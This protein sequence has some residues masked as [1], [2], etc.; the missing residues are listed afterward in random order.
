MTSFMTRS[1][2]ITSS[3]NVGG[4]K[5][6]VQLFPAFQ[7]GCNWVALKFIFLGEVGQSGVART[8]VICRLVDPS[9]NIEPSSGEK[10]EIK[11]FYR[12]GSSIYIWLIKSRDVPASEYLIDDSLTV[13]CAI[14]VLKDLKHITIPSQEEE[15]LPMPPSDMHK[16]FGDLLQ[17]QTGADVTFTVS[18]ESFAAHKL[19]LAARSPVFMA[20]FFGNMEEMSSKCVQIEDMEAAVF[21]AMLHFIYTDTAPE[22]DEDPEAAATL[23]QHL[24]AAADRY[25]LD[26]LKLICECKL[27]GF[28]DVE[29]AATTLALAEQ[30]NCSLLKAKCVEFVTASPEKLDGVLE[31]E[32]YKHLVAS[33]PLVLT[34]L[35]KAARGRKN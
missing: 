10:C 32:G 17:S 2:Y 30:H 20:E 18:G 28:I 15:P 26:R 12:S 14:T 23:A 13:E 7:N 31:T 4:Y 19:V 22:L 35:L 34:E 25:G 5:W 27:S 24:L 1:D 29:T 11:E 33:C 9:G 8:R 21:K 16:H 3:W 6:E